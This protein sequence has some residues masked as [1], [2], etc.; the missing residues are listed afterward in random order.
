MWWKS[1]EEDL[2]QISWA[3]TRK[4]VLLTSITQH[5]GSY[6]LIMP[7]GCDGGVWASSEESSLSTRSCSRRLIIPSDCSPLDTLASPLGASLTLS[8]RR[9]PDS[10]GAR[11]F[12]LA[13]LSP[14][15]CCLLFYTEI[16]S[17]FKQEWSLDLLVPQ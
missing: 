15:T 10:V 16:A 17:A 14:S 5:I 2:V 11:F 7:A 12:P 13:H 3:T 9:C 6:F 8:P 1:R 4:A